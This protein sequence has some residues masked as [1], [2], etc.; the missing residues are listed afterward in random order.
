LAACFASWD[1]LTYFCDIAGKRV[2]DAELGADASALGAGAAG[3]KED[4]IESGVGFN[5]FF[6]GKFGVGPVGK[7]HGGY[8]IWTV[9]LGGILWERRESFERAW[10]WDIGWCDYGG[11]RLREE[12]GGGVFDLGVRVGKFFDAGVRHARETLDTN[13]VVLNRSDK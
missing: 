2:L 7:E 12:D 6:R 9:L 5:G 10:L 13:E 1:E 11:A 4:G 3:V 8:R